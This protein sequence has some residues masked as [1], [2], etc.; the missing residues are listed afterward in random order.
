MNADEEH[1]ILHLVMI[2]FDC[3]DCCSMRQ[4]NRSEAMSA[5]EYRSRQRAP[6]SRRDGDEL[7]DMDW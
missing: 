3:V 4:S 2:V 6:Y 7:F 1:R 5:Y